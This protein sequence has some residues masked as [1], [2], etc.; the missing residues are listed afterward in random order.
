[1]DLFKYFGFFIMLSFIVLSGCIGQ[2]PLGSD[3]NFMSSVTDMQ[4]MNGFNLFIGSS[5]SD[6]QPYEG[7]DSFGKNLL[8]VGHPITEY[9]YSRLM[10]GYSPVIVL[11]RYKNIE[12]IADIQSGGNGD[13]LLFGGPGDDL[14]YGNNGD[15]E[16]HGGPGNN[17]LF[18]GI[19][20]D[21]L[22][23]DDGDDFIYVS[24]GMDHINGGNGNDH[25]LI[26]VFSSVQGNNE[27]FGDSG[28]D[29]FDYNVGSGVY[30]GRDVLF[31]GF[32]QDTLKFNANYTFLN[33]GVDEKGDFAEY[34][35]QG[36]IVR[37]YEI[38]NVS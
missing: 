3:L 11:L 5:G 10:E 1:M 9:D 28:N 37:V 14:Q 12:D 19:G 4:G 2:A 33:S 34:N 35:L 15:D 21:Y 31:G 13:D 24:K 38:E 26:E 27:I 36:R 32:G 22:Q 23:G 18:G 30:S 29:L 25:I 17:S 8:L 20:D 7:Y 6:V 16:I